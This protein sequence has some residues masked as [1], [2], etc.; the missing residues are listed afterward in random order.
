MT[1]SHGPIPIAN[2][3]RWSATVPLQTVVAWLTPTKSANRR[4]NLPI[5][6]PREE[7]QVE[8]R[9][10]LTLCR[11]LPFKHGWYRG[12]TSASD[13]L[14]L[15]LHTLD[16]ISQELSC[17][18]RNDKNGLSLPGTQG[19]AP[20][21]KTIFQEVPEISHGTAELPSYTNRAIQTST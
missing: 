1:S 15:F 14:C 2:I 6:S 13:R 16:V 10:S 11:S 19:C 17:G 21:I 12:Y 4:S 3:A 8:S 9:H 20:I 5:N 7:I 18:N